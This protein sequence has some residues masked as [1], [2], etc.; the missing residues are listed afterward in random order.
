MFNNNMALDFKNKNIYTNKK[1]MI[2]VKFTL[3]N[4]KIFLKYKIIFFNEIYENVS[5]QILLMGIGYWQRQYITNLS[6][7]LSGGMSMQEK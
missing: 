6:S 2:A 7:K 5:E 1:Y 4:E 3:I